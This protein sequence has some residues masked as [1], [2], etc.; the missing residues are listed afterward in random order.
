ME[1]TKAI[2]VATA[3][4]IF[5]A[6][7]ALL[8]ANTIFRCSSY[9]W[10]GNRL[11]PAAICLVLA[12]CW[13][14]ALLLLYLST[15]IPSSLHVS[16]RVQEDDQATW[17]H[18]AYKSV[19]N[20]FQC[21]ILRVKKAPRVPPMD[22]ENQSRTEPA[23]QMRHAS[24][25]GMEKLYYGTS[26][27]GSQEP[28]RV[29]PCLP[30]QDSEAQRGVDDMVITQPPEYAATAPVRFPH[31][32]TPASTPSASPPPFALPPPITPPPPPPPPSPSANRA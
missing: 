27:N 29:S 2:L 25:D 30:T 26:P 10:D 13:P 32:P 12:L 17:Y 1:Q 3:A 15:L 18:S 23:L 24:N 20:W 5:W 21:K 31:Q 19:T 7:P 16:Q 4:V 9:R 22:I 28:Q 11:L 8:L 14:F 6:V